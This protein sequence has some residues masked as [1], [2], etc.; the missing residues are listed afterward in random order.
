[1]PGAGNK[2]S[3]DVKGTQENLRGAREL[4]K[5]LDLTEPDLK[6]GLIILID[7]L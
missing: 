3:V 4:C 1:M 2:G 5:T 7:H 6:I